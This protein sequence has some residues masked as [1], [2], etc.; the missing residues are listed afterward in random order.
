MKS[1]A[2]IAA[3]VLL[4]LAWPPDPGRA[5]PRRRAVREP[6]DVVFDTDMALDVDDVGALAL[7][8]ALANRGECRIL[9]VGISESARAYDGLWAPAMADAVNT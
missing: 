7:L 2:G 6:V 4:V 5:A 8:H 3:V 1:L 9:A